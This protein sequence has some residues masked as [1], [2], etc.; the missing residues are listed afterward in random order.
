MFISIDGVYPIFVSFN[1][2]LDDL[3]ESKTFL[4]L[5]HKDFGQFLEA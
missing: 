3:L 4:M 1:C 5:F 2:A